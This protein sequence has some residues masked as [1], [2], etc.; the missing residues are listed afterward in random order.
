[1]AS[2]DF[3]LAW[4]SF[5]DQLI[6]DR[7]HLFEDKLFSDVILVSDDLIPIEA[8]KIVLSSASPIFRKLLLMSDSNSSKPIIFLKS[9]NQKQLESL[10]NFIYVGEVSITQDQVEEFIRIGEEFDI[11]DFDVHDPFDE[12]LEEELTEEEEFELNIA[13]TEDSGGI[14]KTDDNDQSSNIKIAKYQSLI[15]RKRK[16]YHFPCDR[17]H[18]VFGHNGHLRDHVQVVHEQRRFECNRCEKSFTSKYILVN[19]IKMYHESEPFSYE[20]T[21]DGC[22]KR[23]QYLQSMNDHKKAEHEEKKFPCPIEGCNHTFKFRG[24]ISRHVNTAHP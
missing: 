16:K 9:L 2:A 23:Y 17:C 20:C 15:E 18:R 12:E 8:H 13:E 14:V 22:T 19:H 5:Q 10:L 11:K 24:N 4:N 7:K 3:T 1:M 21:V 6:N